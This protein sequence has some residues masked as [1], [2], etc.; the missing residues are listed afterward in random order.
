MK[1]LTRTIIVLVIINLTTAGF[2]LAQSAVPSSTNAPSQQNQT[3]IE[4]LRDKLAAA[5]AAAIKAQDELNARLQNVNEEKQQ[6]DLFSRNVTRTITEPRTGR[7]TMALSTRI[8][9][10]SSG[11]SRS[12]L[13][14]P[15]AEMELENLA[16]INTDMSVMSR[17]FSKKL[18][19]ETDNRTSSYMTMGMGDTMLYTP[20]IG[21]G[22]HSRTAV[23]SIYL[24]GYG[25]L[26]MMKVDFLLTPPPDAPQEEQAKE[27]DDSDPVWA[28]TIQ[29]MYEP[30]GADITRDDSQEEKYDAEKVKELKKTLI[31]TLK[32]AANIRG[33]KSDESVILSVTG[34]GRS[35]NIFVETI[36]GT[37]DYIIWDK[38]E[39]TTKI[40]KGGLP[41]D[42]AHSTQT[43]L[44]IR[45]KKSDIDAFAKDTLSFDQFSQKIQMLTCPYLVENVG[46]TSSSLGL[47]VPTT[48]GRSAGR[49]GR[50][51]VRPSIT[52]RTERAGRSQR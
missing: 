27:E 51:G 40:Y 10:L 5:E 28:Q 11:D 12:I 18:T 24:E 19:Q 22:Q 13:I 47:T 33:L 21:F 34:S 7:R 9:S 8:P 25:A 29:E 3:E 32:H 39:N 46:G 45:A 16:A 48:R 50:S 38:N 43:I 41:D 30:E 35:T 31:E 20:Y 52:P 42:L 4:L 2:A 26:F 1:T 49:T 17:I 6:L 15:T 23:E 14:I 44:I 37:N 36:T